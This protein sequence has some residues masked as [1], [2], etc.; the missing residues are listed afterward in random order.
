[1]MRYG[2]VGQRPTCDLKNPQGVNSS[3]EIKYLGLPTSQLEL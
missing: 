1:M 2:W 3:T